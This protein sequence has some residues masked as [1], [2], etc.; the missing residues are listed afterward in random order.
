MIPENLPEILWWADK[1]LPEPPTVFTLAFGLEFKHYEYK[2]LAWKLFK[3][4]R[5]WLSPEEL[6][7]YYDQKLTE[8]RGIN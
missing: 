6:D 7:W 2:R 3:K 5:R 4:E 1:N 8:A